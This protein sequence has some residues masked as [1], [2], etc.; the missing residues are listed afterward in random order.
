MKDTSRRKFFR[1]LEA[2][3]TALVLGRLNPVKADFED[4][5]RLD[6]PDDIFTGA[7]IAEDLATTFY[8][9]GLN[10]KVIQDP[11]LAGPG[12]SAT[13]VTAMGNAG[14]VSYLQAALSTE[15]EHANLLRSLLKGSDAGTD[16]YQTF[17]FPAGTFDTLNAFTK[18]LDALES[19][20]IGAYLVAVRQFSYM[21]CQTRVNQAV[22]FNIDNTHA[23]GVQDLEYFAQVAAS[24]AGVEAE[25]RVLGRVITN[26]NPA[27]NISYEQTGSITN[28]Y[29]GS[30]SAITALTP[31]LVP[32]T[33]PAYNIPWYLI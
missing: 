18:M 10:G 23:F 17:Y 20:L 16:R 31:F 32:S 21:A 33:G 13:N 22:Y 12:G 9:N 25:H 3:V 28:V 1:G 26:T 29:R 6:G 24:I 5:A 30:T 27:N 2:S 4:A 14:N 11:A 19:A 7:L 15:I 8:Y